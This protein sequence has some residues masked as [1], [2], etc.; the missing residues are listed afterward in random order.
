MKRPVL[1]FLLLSVSFAVG[2]NAQTSTFTAVL[3]GANELPA[4]F[5]ARA[6]GFAMVT[7]DPAAGTVAFSL[8]APNLSSPPNAAHIHRGAAGSGPKPVVIPLN[9]PFV[10]GYS[11][12]TTTG[13]LSSLINEIL[14]NPA[15]FYA[16]IHTT[17]YGGGPFA[18][19]LCPL[20]GR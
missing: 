6:V 3:V 2:A 4:A 7:L 19:N 20:R 13:V 12:G 15:G 10:N 18:A 16:N 5:D 17:Q 11:N 8:T 14:A 9:A 1:L